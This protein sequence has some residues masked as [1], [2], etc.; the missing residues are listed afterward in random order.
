MIAKN[1][2]FEDWEARKLQDPEFRAVAEELE[3]AYQITRL[4][5][6]LGLT[7]K[8]VAKLV[9]TSQPSIARLESGKGEPSLS[10]LRRVVHAL[11][12]QLQ[13]RIIAP[14]EGIVRE[15][16][17]IRLSPNLETGQEEETA[18]E[19]LEIEPGA[20]QISLSPRWSWSS[21]SSNVPEPI[22]IAL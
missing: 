1:T 4:R 11:G 20:K 17:P 3:P 16:E 14:E 12:G 18:V 6:G 21:P 22:E 7:Q 19:S 13:V 10:F 2:Q 8:Q 9:G 5:L 15:K